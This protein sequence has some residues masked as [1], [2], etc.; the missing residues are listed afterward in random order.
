M[1][2]L[3]LACF[4]N[5]ELVYTVENGD[6]LRSIAEKFSTTEN[7]IICDNFLNQAVKAGEKLYIKKQKN[8][9]VVTPYDTLKSIALKFNVSEQKILEENKITYIYAG[10]RIVIP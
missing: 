5:L 7:L 1:E 8:V 6:D 4:M 9:Y 2:K 10:E 3:K